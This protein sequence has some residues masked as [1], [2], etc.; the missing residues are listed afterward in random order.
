[1]MCAVRD[2]RGC[3]FMNAAIE[4]PESDHRVRTAVSGHR[5]WFFES[6]CAV[7][8]SA[9]HSDPDRAGRALVLLRDGSMMGGYLDD[10]DEIATALEWAVRS[11]VGDI[12]PAPAHDRNEL[13]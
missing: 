3:P 8:M 6:V 5:A 4:Y 7:L 11:V 13:P 2:C 9:Q 1:M 12:G 10:P